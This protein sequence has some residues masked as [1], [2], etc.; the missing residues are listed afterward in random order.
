MLSHMAALVGFA[1]RFSAASLFKIYKKEGPVHA[2]GSCNRF[3]HRFM[4]GARCCHG[5]ARMLSHRHV[6]LSLLSHYAVT[7]S[8]VSACLSASATFRLHLAVLSRPL[9]RF[10]SRALSFRP[11]HALAMSCNFFRCIS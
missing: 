8:A 6:V 7:N 3:M 5:D 11:S 10:V 4:D 1:K 2:I 9:S